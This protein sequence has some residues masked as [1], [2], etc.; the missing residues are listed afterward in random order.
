MK[1]KRKFTSVLGVIFFLSLTLA[2]ENCSGVNFSS[3]S[4]SANTLNG[5]TGNVTTTGGGT[6]NLTKVSAPINVLFV[7]DRSGSNSVATQSEGTS[8][9]QTQD[10]AGCAPPTDPNKTF[11]GGSISNFLNANQSNTS[12]SWG[13]L[14]FSGSSAQSYITNGGGA[15]FGNAAAMQTA[16]DKFNSGSDQDATPYLAAL[17]A[18]KATIANDPGL[19]ITGTRAPLYEIIFLSDGYPTDA[20]NSDGSVN[21]TSLNTAIAGIS[22]LAPGRIFLS[23]VYY[24]TINDPT[25]AST[26]QSMATAGKGQF[27]NADTGNTSSISINN[28]ITIPTGDCAQ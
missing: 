28:L 11:R 26:L 7:V 22:N 16:I 1:F 3:S 4:D 15:S 27:V 8:T 10:Q 14:A 25:A 23:A 9:C 20:L 18:A 12:F 21:L 13:F 17:K 6:C 2:F 19:N 24:G 5:G